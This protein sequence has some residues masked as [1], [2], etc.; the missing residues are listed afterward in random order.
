MTDLDEARARDSLFDL[1]VDD[2]H[3]RTSWPRS[4]LQAWMITLG[5]ELISDTIDKY[6]LDEDEPRVPNN[7]G[8]KE[9]RNKAYKEL[10]SMHRALRE[11][12]KLR[13]KESS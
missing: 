13:K 3:E 5:Y 2:I 7:K 8:A 12:V 10:I 6:T 11:E 1:A 9:R 4:Q